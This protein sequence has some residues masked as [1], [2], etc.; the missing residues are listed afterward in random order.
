MRDVVHVLGRLVE[1]PAIPGR[2][3]VADHSQLDLLVQWHE[4]FARDAGLKAYDPRPGIEQR[5]GLGALLWWQVDGAQ[6]S[7]AGHTPPLSTPGGT[8]AR[9]GPVY[10]PAP[11][12]RRG[13]ASALTAEVV[14]R[15]Q[16]SSTVVM[17]FADAGNATSN[18]VYE[19]LGFRPTGEIVEVELVP[20]Q[21]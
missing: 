10:T 20:L 7:L 5:L 8:V 4:E 12:R 11:F 1:P 16:P 17:L 3:V 6:V 13:Y 18:G 9:V 14:R 19:R 2:A 15:L 21:S